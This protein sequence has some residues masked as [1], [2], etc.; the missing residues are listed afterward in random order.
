MMKKICCIFNVAP[1]YRKNIYKKMDEELGCDFYLGD[2][3]HTPLKLMDYESLKNFKGITKFIPLFSPLYWQ[4]GAV[5]LVFRSCYTD[6]I[7]SGEP[8]GLSQWL[9]LLFGK[10]LKKRVFLWS[11]GWYGRESSIKKLLKKIFCGLAEGVFLYGNYA[12]IL[13]M[14]NGFNERKL[15]V[16]YN[17]LDYDTQIAIRRELDKIP[18]HQHI[19]RDHFRNENPV[20]IFLGRLTYRKSLDLLIEVVRKLY[21][22]NVQVNTVLVG[23]G[24]AEDSLKA[25][26]KQYNLSDKI[27]FYGE[28]FDEKT[29]AILLY[30]ADVCVSPG[31]V[32]LTAIH[33]FTF[34]CPVIT[35]RQFQT[36][37]PEFEIVDEYK[38][39]MFF[40]KGN[41]DDLA[42][43]IKSFLDYE[44]NNRGQIRQD[45]YRQVDEKYNPH[46]QIEV[47]KKV[48]YK[49]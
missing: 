18:E 24:E 49:G 20:L 21:S 5:K 40:E 26:T 10:L 36:Q 31:D 42:E 7:V 38:T 46:Y 44:K 25:I 43:K 12:K 1:Y 16:I 22:E 37:G 48:I 33:S 39:G 14:E 15:H 8:K 47:L 45:C 29:N 32:G 9:I 4:K 6:F 2:R 30:S 28:C 3:T 19:Y 34:G 23:S 27:W 41:A 35:H 11:H 13:M 17:S